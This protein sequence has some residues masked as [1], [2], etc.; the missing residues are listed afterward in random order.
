M[1]SSVVFFPC[2]VASASVC[3]RKL[4]S[5]KIL[6]KKLNMLFGVYLHPTEVSCL[7][8][9]SASPACTKM[10]TAAC[11]SDTLAIILSSLSTVLRSLSSRL[12]TS[13]SACVS[14][15]GI[16]LRAICGRL[17]LLSSVSSS[18]RMA[19]A[20]HCDNLA[21]SSS[22]VLGLGESTVGSH[23]AKPVQAISEPVATERTPAPRERLPDR[24]LLPAGAINFRYRLLVLKFSNRYRQPIC[25]VL[26][27][28]I[29]IF[30]LRT[31]PRST[32]FS[33]I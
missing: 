6:L 31:R 8:R 28:R 25:T 22:C 29:T 24:A 11:F 18:V 21:A 19:S 16:L 27:V 5:V 12:R 7:Y 17:S 32:D 10:V 2:G 3:S 33:A 23:A 20:S 4:E 1:Q 26:A 30:P 15:D 14:A 13:C 9:R